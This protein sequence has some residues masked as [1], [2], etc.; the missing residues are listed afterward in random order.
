[1]TYLKN[2]PWN[3]APPSPPPRNQNI[4][5]TNS[6]LATRRDVCPPSPAP[7]RKNFEGSPAS[8]RRYV[9]PVPPTPPPRRLSDSGS[10]HLHT[11]Y[12]QRL[13]CQ[14]KLEEK[15]RRYTPQPRRR[16]VCQFNDI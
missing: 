1:M 16:V 9:S 15:D 4:N 10:S 7:I 2:V 5:V 11:F 6:P 8:S 3:K 13:F 14:P 12:Q